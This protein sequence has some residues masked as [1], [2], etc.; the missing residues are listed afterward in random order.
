MKVYSCNQAF[1]NDSDIS[2]DFIENAMKTLDGV[3]CSVLTVR[4]EDK[5]LVIVGD[6]ERARVQYSQFETNRKTIYLND[7]NNLDDE[8]WVRLPGEDDVIPF[9]ETISFAKAVEVCRYFVMNEG[10]LHEEFSM[11]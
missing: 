7:G 10:K 5:A 6:G 11:E 3:H 2:V 8:M 9:S 4:H 1:E